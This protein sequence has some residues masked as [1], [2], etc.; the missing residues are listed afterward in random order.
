MQP[1]AGFLLDNLSAQSLR[2]IV[3]VYQRKYAWDD[4]NCLQ[5]WEDVVSTGK[6]DSGNHFTGSIVWVHN[7]DIGGDGSITALVI[8]GQQ[9]MTT[10]S[11]LLLALARYAKEHDGVAPDG[12]ALDFYW[13]DIE[14][15]ICST[16]SDRTERIA[17]S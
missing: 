9:R 4:V 11:L 1:S 8:D 12:T 14:K 3:P 2:Y 17:L 16:T 13:D 5:L 10:M 6:A 15:K 7:G